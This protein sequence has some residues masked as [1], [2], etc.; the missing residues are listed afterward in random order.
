MTKIC[1]KAT[2]CGAERFGEEELAI[3]GEL[4]EEKYEMKK[5]EKLEE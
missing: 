4:D 5:L 1:Y 2:T 3:D